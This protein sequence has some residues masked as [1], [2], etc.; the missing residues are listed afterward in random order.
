M[1]Y[2]DS[3]MLFAV[4]IVT[5]IVLIFAAAIL[6]EYCRS[7]LVEKVFYGLLREWPLKSILDISENEGDT[8][9]DRQT[10]R[11]TDRVIS[12]KILNKLH[13]TGCCTLT[14]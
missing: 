4:R 10:D 9:T 1:K 2:V 7:L 12:G 13:L 5:S 14:C 8:L 11:Q 6:I 3:P